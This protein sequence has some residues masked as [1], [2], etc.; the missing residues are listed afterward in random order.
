M[1]KFKKD[2]FDIVIKVVSFILKWSVI[3]LYV[4]LGLM[5]IA[6][7]ASI[8]V[9]K[10]LYDFD[11]SLLGNI[12]VQIANVVYEVT[13]GTFEGIINVKSIVIQGI[14]TGIVQLGIL[15][16]ILIML[17]NIVSDVKKENP[18]SSENFKRLKF[19]GFAYIGA[20]VVSPVFNSWL[21]FRIVEALDL[22]RIDL[23]YSLNLQSIFMG[24]IILGL[25]S[26][27]RYGASLQEDHDLTV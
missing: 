5:A 7:I 20:G 4:V 8:F 25:A 2:N 10:G 18:F 14:I 13:E 11:L 3:L 22:F 27:F 9:P 19:I 26:V 15:Q 23:N 21:M 16:F 6:F 1:E 12:N 24:L 17:K